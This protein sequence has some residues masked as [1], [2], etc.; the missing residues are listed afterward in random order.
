M[1]RKYRGKPTWYTIPPCGADH[2]QY[3][4]KLA[5]KA[6]HFKT[7][8]GFHYEL[9]KYEA[10]GPISHGKVLLAHLF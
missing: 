6:S 2:S 7:S 3:V 5:Q 9:I 10:H 1:Y 4:K 8:M